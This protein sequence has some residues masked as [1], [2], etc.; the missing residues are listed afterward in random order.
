LNSSKAFSLLEL[1]VVIALLGIVSLV[2]VPNVREW[3]VKR[4]MEKDMQLV[5]GLVNKIRSDL[6]HGLYEMGGIFFNN[7]NGQGL[8][9]NIRYMDSDKYQQYKIS[10]SSTC[11]DVVSEWT[12][13]EIYPNSSPELY[14]TFSNI[15]MRDATKGMCF[16]KNFTIDKAGYQ[17]FCHKDRNAAPACDMTS[18][19]DPYYRI[20]VKRTAAIILERYI[21]AQGSWKQQ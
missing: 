3:L 15:K 17:D 12:V 2:A 1:L 14:S 9:V 7:N 5:V 20:N 6:D 18:S 11:N 4:E 19:N 10:N 13:E 8:T 21:Y 16:N